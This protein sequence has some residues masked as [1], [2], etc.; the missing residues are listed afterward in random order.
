MP[1]FSR[2]RPSLSFEASSSL[3]I[4]LAAVANSRMSSWDV[5]KL[6]KPFKI[7]QD[8]INQ[9][10]RQVNSFYVFLTMLTYI[11]MSYES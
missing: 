9:N 6:L 7:I 2:A 10:Q 3:P 8:K 1:R 4:C 5:V 11:Y